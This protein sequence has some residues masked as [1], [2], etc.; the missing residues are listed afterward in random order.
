MVG[1]SDQVRK[2]GDF[3]TV[4]DTGVPML[5]VRSHDGELRAFLN[6]C[7]HRGSAVE[8]DSCGSG[9][10][11]FS[12]PWHGWN[13]RNDGTLVGIPDPWGFPDLNKQEY[14]LTSLPVAERHGLVFAI[15]NPAAVLDLDE[16][17]GPLDGELARYQLDEFEVYATNV[18]TLDMNWK[19]AVD[20]FG[21]AYHVRYLHRDTGAHLFYS[22]VITFEPFG[23]H[24]RMGMALRSLEKLRQL[25]E[26]EWDLTNHVLYAYLLYPNVALSWT[27]ENLAVY[28]MYPASDDPNRSVVHTSLHRH[29]SSTRSDAA[30]D[31]NMEF[32]INVTE[33]DF[34]MAPSAQAALATGLKDQVVYGSFEA[35]LIHMHTQYRHALGLEPLEIVEPT[36][37]T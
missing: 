21:E 30:W 20:T 9:R 35:P 1:F 23:R 13:Y 26:D 14:G 32:L 28:R 27:S 22:T 8:F 16:F 12:C 7:T 18:R 19:L 2:P 31:K 34:S 36:A 37:E 33:E 15:G 29:P 3:F 24:T 17:L 25:P 5:V 10:K 4:N 11:V 6:S